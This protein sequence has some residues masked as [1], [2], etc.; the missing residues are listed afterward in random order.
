MTPVDDWF[1]YLAQ[2]N[3][4]PETLRT[5]RSVMGHYLAAVPDPLTAD[6]ADA[7]QWWAT[8]DEHA[9]KSRQRSLSCVRS[10]YT[11]AM[12]F[13]LVDRDPTR[14]LD[15]PS[16][17]RRLPRPI[18]KAD[19]RKALDNAPDD[20]RRAIALGAYAGLRVSEV[21]DLDW[22]DIDTDTRRLM[23]RGK[24]DKDRPVGIGGRLM[25]ELLPEAVGNVV[26]AGASRYTAASLQRRVNR[27]LTSQG[28]DGTFHKLRAR[29]VTVALAEGAPLLSVSRAVGHTSTTTTALYALTADAD[30]DLIAE[31]VSR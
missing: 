6:V 2:R 1:A 4:S 23:V 21:A 31:A 15:A 30:L 20:L 8:L 25:D 19:L 3:R 12:R 29:Y 7:E 28:I 16:Q 27:Y 5:Y 24:G 26:T 13:D 17:G 22:S 10:F 18:G 14:R 9:V 11:W